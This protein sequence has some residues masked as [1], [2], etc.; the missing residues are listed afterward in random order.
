MRYSK[1]PTHWPRGFI[2]LSGTQELAE[3]MQ[4]PVFAAVFRRISI[5]PINLDWLS[6]DDLQAFFFNF[7]LDF[8]PGCPKED[9]MISAARFT[10]SDDTWNS[11]ISIDMFKQFLMQR[12]STF[13]AGEL[14]EDIA[15][16]WSPFIVPVAM[17]AR[18]LDYLCQVDPARAHLTSYPRVGHCVALGLSLIHI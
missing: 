17:R 7:V 11:G 16:P 2:V 18:F 5:P 8:V 14:S 10:L 1:A 12:I 6:A 15:D 4:D 9:L 13:R 3:S